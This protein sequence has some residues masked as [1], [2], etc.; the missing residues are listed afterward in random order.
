MRQASGYEGKG[1]GTQTIY[2][3][4]EATGAGSGSKTS[5]LRR[6]IMH[7]TDVAASSARLF[8]LNVPD[9]ASLN[10]HAAAGSNL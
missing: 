2:L 5:S 10:V 7:P 1:P 9:R 4:A 3:P 6:G 8:R